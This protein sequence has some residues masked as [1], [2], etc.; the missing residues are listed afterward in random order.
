MLF[1]TPRVKIPLSEIQFTFARSGGPGGQNVNKVNSKAVLRWP[2]VASPSLPWDVR[3]RFMTQYGSRLTIEGELIITSQ[4]H[5]DQASNVDD[6]LEKLKHML[7]S[8][9]TPPIPRRPT[10]PTLGSQIRR[11]ETKK[12]NAKKK[13]QR[14]APDVDD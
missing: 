4:K 9:A 8:V 5:R 6:C 1:V 2:V 13:Q 11:T 14:R 12:V 7:I 10:K 3:A